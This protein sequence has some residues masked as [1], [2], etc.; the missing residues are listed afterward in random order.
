M[1]SFRAAIS[2]GRL[3]HEAI[4]RTLAL[5]LASGEVILS[6]AAQVH[7]ERRHPVDYPRLLPFL[8]SVIASPLYVGDDVKNAGKI[9]FVGRAGVGVDF[10]LVAI[11][12]TL[13]EKGRY[14]VVSFYPVS[15]EKIEARRLKGFLRLLQQ[16]RGPKPP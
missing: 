13:D 15:R 2:L 7:A 9:E 11:S 14:H 6:R 8:G 4:N 3:P 5:E 10:M 1:G 16:E 12:I